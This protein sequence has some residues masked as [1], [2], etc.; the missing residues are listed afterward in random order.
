MTRWITIFLVFFSSASFAA[1]VKF[2]YDCETIGTSIG[3]EKKVKNKEIFSYSESEMQG[4]S[5]EKKPW[6]IL[7]AKFFSEG[8]KYDA[9][10]TSYSDKYALYT[11]ASQ[12]GKGF[13]S[14]VNSFMYFIDFDALTLER[15]VISFPRGE[16]ERAVGVCKKL[17]N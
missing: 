6:K 14:K 3:G 8:K 5:A 13:S 12:A 16:E 9:K 4:S 17:N 2:S 1:S 11:Y 10:L 7:D 15:V